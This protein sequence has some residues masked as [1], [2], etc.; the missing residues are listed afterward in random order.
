MAVEFHSWLISS[1][2]S[3]V[4]RSGCW[5]VGGGQLLEETWIGSELWLQERRE[6][7]GTFF[8]GGSCGTAL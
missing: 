8:S 6:E 1:F 7:K 2:L 5:G 4:V 3:Y